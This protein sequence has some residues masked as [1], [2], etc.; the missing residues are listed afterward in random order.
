MARFRFQVNSGQGLVL[1]GVARSASS[2]ELASYLKQVGLGSARIE[3]VSDWHW[4]G[5]RA[6]TQARLLLIRQL[7]FSFNNGVS[8]SETLHGIRLHHTSPDIAALATLL[9]H[10]LSAGAPLS[11]SLAR[12]PGYFPNIVCS[13]V[14]TAEM[15]GMLGSTLDRCAELIEEENDLRRRMV[16]VLV[17]PVCI[18]LIFL[19]LL[20]LFALY[21]VP[22]F[23]D[24]FTSFGAEPPVALQLVAAAGGLM[25]QGWAM[26]FLAQGV[27]ALGIWAYGWARSEAG[28]VKLL[29][30]ATDTPGV[31]SLYRDYLV[32]HFC[33][34][35]KE[36]LTVGLDI[37]SAL[38]T[39][40][41]EAEGELRSALDLTLV[42][43]IHGQ[44]LA[45]A[46]A[47]HGYFPRLVCQ[48]VA[49]GEESGKLSS[50]FGSLHHYYRQSFQHRVEM[51]LSLL[52]PVIIGTMGLLVAG[53][54]LSIVGPMFS[55]F[56]V[57][58]S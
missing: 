43:I 10:S 24:V 11:A 57:V 32:T 20:G 6:D 2:N 21:I 33:L 56:Q 53:F 37:A 44:T 25:T 12:F 49:A 8:L 39:C 35:M 3:P 52:E 42:E 55:L 26:L 54:V 23:V 50:M 15:S 38:S 18:S 22:V 19:V 16:S 34:M 41:D 29:A 46:L 4:A 9:G 14:K 48:L 7:A 51:L 47:S 31:N 5:S 1:D 17:Y 36:M 30:W 13:M 27:L 58:G 45:D 40:R 28:R